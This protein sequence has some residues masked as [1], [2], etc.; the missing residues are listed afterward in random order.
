MGF[1]FLLALFVLIGLMW[2]FGWYGKAPPEQR[3]RALKLITLYGIAGVLLLLV[4]TGRIHWLFSAFALAV[5]IVQRI[6]MAKRAWNT[7]QSAKDAFGQQQSSNAD[8]RRRAGAMTK[9][10]AYEILGLQPNASKE[11]IIEAHRR[12]MQKNHP[13]RGGNDYLASR[14]NRAKDILLGK[15]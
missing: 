9:D 5:P 1:R 14:I 13:D 11:E 2:F 12:L 15:S 3:A 6:V 4:V 8:T 10:E 7:F